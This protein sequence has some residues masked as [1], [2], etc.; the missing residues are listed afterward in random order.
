M[1]SPGEDGLAEQLPPDSRPDLHLRESL[2]RERLSEPRLGA[3][4]RACPELL[5]PPVDLRVADHDPEL[6]PGLLLELGFLHELVEELVPRG[7]ERRRAGCGEDLALQPVA[8]PVRREHGGERGA[9]DRLVADERDGVR[10]HLFR[11]GGAA[12]R[13]EGGGEQRQKSDEREAAHLE[14]RREGRERRAFARSFVP[15]GAGRESIPP[16]PGR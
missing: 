3:S 13:H 16:R 4:R 10:G 8:L 15:V 12:A 1:V 2:L 14:Q 5:H 7:Q 6:R 9:R 11:A